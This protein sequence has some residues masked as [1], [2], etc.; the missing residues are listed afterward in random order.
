MKKDDVILLEDRGLVSISGEDAKDFLQN[1]ITNDVNKVSNT[2]TIFSGLF[3]PQGKYLFEF[4]VIQS[5]D[6]YLL[7]C[8][9]KFTSELINYFSIKLLINL[10]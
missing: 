3:T 4:F 9:N 8:D 7:D 5:R 2:N 1:I 10:R 6:S